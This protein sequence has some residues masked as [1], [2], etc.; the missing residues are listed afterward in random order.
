[1]R[2]ILIAAHDPDLVIGRDGEMPWHYSEDFRHF[3]RETMGHPVLMGRGVFEE[4]GEK[5]LPGRRN[6]V[7]TRSRS[8]PEKKVEVF[9]EIDKA[10]EALASEPVVYVIGG[11]EIYREL[12]GR[13]DG[14]VIT[15]IKKRYDGNVYF[16]E[17]RDRVGE[18]WKETSRKETEEMAFVWYER[19]PDPGE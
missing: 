9:S 6:I 14:M 10:L 1:M 5:P 4:I 13:A 8:Y 11:G 15:E 12:I 3:K 19:I 17:Y 18:V 7:L 16:P 2:L